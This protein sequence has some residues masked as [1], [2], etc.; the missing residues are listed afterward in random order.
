ML[1]ISSEHLIQMIQRFIL[2]LE[3]FG[4]RLLGSRMILMRQYHC[5]LSRVK[6]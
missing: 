1:P 6:K 5:L 2:L 3:K 4:L